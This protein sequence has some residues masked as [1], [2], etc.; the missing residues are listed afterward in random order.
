MNMRLEIFLVST[1][2]LTGC[3]SVEGL[4]PDIAAKPVP[5]RLDE[6][7]Y[8]NV[9]RSSLTKAG[10]APAATVAPPPKAGA[11]QAATGSPLPELCYTGKGLKPFRPKSSQ[12]YA[13]NAN[14]DERVK[15]ETDSGD[16]VNCYTFKTVSAGQTGKQEV[17]NY[18]YA[19]FGLTDLYCAR[20]FTVTN[21]SEQNRKFGRNFAN[22]IDVLIGA[23]LTSSGA[24]DTAIGI[25]NS[26]FGLVDSTFQ[27]Y[28]SAFLVAPDMSNVRKLV[29]AAQ[30][31][32]RQNAL[33][34][35]EATFPNSFMG[36]RSVVERYAGICSFSGMKELINASLAEKTKQIDKSLDQN[37]D[38]KQSQE[39]SPAETSGKL[40]KKPQEKSANQAQTDDEKP[41]RTFSIPMR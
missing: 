33:K 1:I 39:T 10:A 6:I 18:L 15:G 41:L 5:S 36:A 24:G 17:S 19:G 28:D 12:G 16:V 8:I 23:I 30:N 20:F 34:S 4:R 14:N 22:G 37:A 38:R 29:L 7:A 35:D 26:A 3:T 2:F 11:D 21:A 27:A 40:P 9:L 25:T 31:E 32:Y 13:D